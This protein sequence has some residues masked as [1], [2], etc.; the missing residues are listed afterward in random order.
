MALKIKHLNKNIKSNNK[1]THPQKDVHFF[2]CSLKYHFR[3]GR[4]LGQSA[5]LISVYLTSVMTCNNSLNQLIKI[6]LI[7]SK[8]HK[9][10]NDTNNV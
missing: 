1:Q 7:T 5:N 8:P 3:I 6:H 2:I 4:I 10:F 9:R